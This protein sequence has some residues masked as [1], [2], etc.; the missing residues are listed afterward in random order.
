[1]MQWT[2]RGSGDISSRITRSFCSCYDDGS[3]PLIP[4][5]PNGCTCGER[6]EGYDGK[7]R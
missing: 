1:M 5:N 3:A 2:R 4:G 7:W 6:E